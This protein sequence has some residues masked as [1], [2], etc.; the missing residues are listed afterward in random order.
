MSFIAIQLQ[1]SCIPHS[2]SV[3]HSSSVNVAWAI[4]YGMIKAEIPQAY[5][6]YEVW[7]STHQEEKFIQ[8]MEQ[9]T[10]HVITW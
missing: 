9:E 10:K 2:F 7:V 6:N 8:K 3:H 1:V 5:L 4:C